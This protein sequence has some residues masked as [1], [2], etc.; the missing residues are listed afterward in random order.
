MIRRLNLQDRGEAI[1]LL[2]LQKRAYRQEAD[3]IG[4]EEIPP[5][6]ETLEALQQS[7]ETFYG[8]ILDRQLA[9]AISYKREGD[10]LDIYRMM[11][12]PDYF[13]RGIA[14]A[15]LQFVEGCETGIKRIIVSTGSLNT[16]AC[17]LYEHQGFTATAEE[18]IIP[19]LWI[20]HFEK[21]L[22]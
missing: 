16:P 17:T 21:T 9:G 7:T 18:E 12:H 10:L 1:A 22:C 15:L 11:V 6:H 3:L 8:Y 2:A 5:L 4:S 13:R 14:R 20:T 19:H